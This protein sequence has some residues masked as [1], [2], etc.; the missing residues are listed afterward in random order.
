MYSLSLF[1]PSIVHNLRC[2]S[3]SS[4][5]SE[6]YRCYI[7]LAFPKSGWDLRLSPSIGRLGTLHHEPCSTSFTNETFR[8]YH[9]PA[10]N[11]LNQQSS[12]PTGISTDSLFNCSRA[13]L[14]HHR[15]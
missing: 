10:E 15:P 3:T 5:V 14:L 8:M 9:F 2:S 4:T 1:V 11:R 6:Y 13:N 7:L 12:N